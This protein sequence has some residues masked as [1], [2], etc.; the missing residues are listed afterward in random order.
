MTLLHV[1]GALGAGGAE[2][3]VANLLCELRRRGW[4]VELMSVSSRTDA[5]T[6]GMIAELAEAGVPYRTGPSEAVRLGGI[7]WY[8]GQM[9]RSRPELVHL[10][11]INTE[12][13]Q[14]F[15][16]P[17][18][19]PRRALVR[20]VH[21][22]TL[23]TKDM[24]G[25]ALR[26][27][28]VAY[29][30]FCSEASEK[31]ARQLVRG[32]TR[33]IPYGLRILLPRRT[34]EARRQAR[35]K[36][37]LEENRVHF[38]HVGRMVGTSLESAAKAHD[39]LIRAWRE[40]GAGASGALLHLLGDGNLRPRLTLLAQE[41]AS[42]RFEGIRP[43]VADWLVAADCFVMPSRFEGLPVAGIEAVTAGLPCLFSRIA[44]LVE[45]R[46]A[47][48]LWSDVDDVAALAANLEEFAA[49][50]REVES[51]AVEAAR[52]RFGIAHAAA[53]YANVYRELGLAANAMAQEST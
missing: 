21:N 1:I 25:F 28:P 22:T 18:W 47:V 51:S 5:A 11:N 13:F 36:L 7:L 26:R 16:P 32:P 49:N 52:E 8:I 2:R 20:T 10:H 3:F 33:V 35:A 40:S 39:V 43:D 46:P 45:L 6:R 29:T 38:L 24:D 27:N 48:A 23:D 53:G 44:P 41:D 12:T 30:I 37:G 4:P 42:I 31:S 15:V 14:M 9:R 50:P 19:R 34:P 17:P